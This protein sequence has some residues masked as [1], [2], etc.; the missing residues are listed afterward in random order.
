MRTKL[1][2]VTN[3]A[4]WALPA[5]APTAADK[6]LL[7]SDTPEEQAAEA[8][9]IVNEVGLLPEQNVVLPSH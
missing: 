6:G 7:E 9:A 3:P 2:P 1:I 5:L 8:E 4:L